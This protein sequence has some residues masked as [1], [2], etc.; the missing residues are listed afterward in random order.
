MSPR[1]VVRACGLLLAVLLA[2]CTSIGSQIVPSTLYKTLTLAPGELARHG[3]A[4]LTPHTVTGQEQDKQALALIFAE[5]LHAQLPKV[6][7]A[8][9]P[10]TLGAINR[11]GLADDY[12]RMVEDYRD[13]GVFQREPLQKIG[14]AAGVRYLAQLKLAAF[15]QDMRERLSLLGLRLFQTQHANIRLYLQV[16]DS[17]QGVIAWEAV[18]EL[19]YSYDSSAERPVTFRQVVQAAAQPLIASLP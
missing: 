15:S 7:I 8:T 3:L 5:S 12:R 6:R 2:G 10:E 11:A 17:E 1:F 4:F 18:E 19:S 9:L 13:T 16:W 14:R